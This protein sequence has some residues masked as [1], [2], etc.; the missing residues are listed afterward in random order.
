[1]LDLSL[2]RGSFETVLADEDGKQDSD[3]WCSH[4]PN[5]QEFWQ[6]LCQWVW[7]LL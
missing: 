2:H 3:R 7:N 4:N 6:I 5:G 1:V